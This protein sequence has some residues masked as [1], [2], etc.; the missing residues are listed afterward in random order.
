MK[1]RLALEAAQ[2]SGQKPWFVELAFN[3]G[4]RLSRHFR[5][6]RRRKARDVDVEVA[7]RERAFLIRR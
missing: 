3:A 6:G 2:A 4:R 5:A 7:A 1:R